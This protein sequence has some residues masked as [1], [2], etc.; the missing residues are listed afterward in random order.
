MAI[1][2]TV[3]SL[4]G[5]TPQQIMAQQAERERS[6]LA[7]VANNPYQQVGT[8]IGIGLGRLFGGESQEMTEAQQRQ[9]EQQKMMQFGSEVEREAAARGMP[10]LTEVE[11]L[12]KRAETLQAM[13]QRFSSLGQPAD[14]VSNLENQA[15]ATRFAALDKQRE[16]EKFEQDTR[17]TELDMKVAE[18]RLDSLQNQDKLTKKDLVEIQLK[19]TPDSYA[20]WLRGE[21]LLVP[22]PRAAGAEETT[23]AIQNFEYMQNL[24][25]D[26]QRQQFMLTN[27]SANSFFKDRGDA[28]VFV[29]PLNPTT[30]L[31]EIP[32]E[33]DPSQ[34]PAIIAKQEQART[35]GTEITRDQLAVG[36]Q[37]DQLDRFSKI[38]EDVRKH[39]G[40][41]RGTGWGAQFPSVQPQAKAFDLKVTQ[42]KDN[43]FLNQIPQLKGMG[44][45][46]NAEGDALRASFTYLN[47]LLP[48]T[49]F[50][51]ELDNIDSIIRTMRNRLNTKK[52]LTPEEVINRPYQA[53]G[54]TTAR[55][56]NVRTGTTSTGVSYQVEEE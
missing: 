55:T 21:G 44:A 52:F 16:L 39:P 8:A 49:E 50:D 29:D 36:G 13:A 40:K 1:R 6:L 10:P 34:E 18:A 24:P 5:A 56:G 32:K 54:A 3:A 7:S 53:D 25:T 2:N 37:L 33:L 9:E 47:T 31:A 12:N 23:A 27:R 45:L 11:E 15:L 38:V 14:L 41:E 42:L 46:S 43:A 30:V 35:A 48:T 20:K 19:A 17:K 51:A 4:F 22:N 28:Y 26:E